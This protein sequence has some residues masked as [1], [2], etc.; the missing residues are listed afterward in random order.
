MTANNLSSNL[1]EVKPQHQRK[2]LHPYALCQCMGTDCVEC[3]KERIDF[4]EQEL[5]RSNHSE[6]QWMLKAR[7][8]MREGQLLREESL[9]IHGPIA[10][11][12]LGCGIGE[13]YS[14]RLSLME[15][16]N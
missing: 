16:P 1:S 8:A 2:S 14:R 5:E 11:L 13:Y 7:D 12:L 3:L 9:N 10:P 15:A 4:L 6:K